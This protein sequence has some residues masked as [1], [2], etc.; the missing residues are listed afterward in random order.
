MLSSCFDSE[1]EK[2]VFFFTVYFF[3]DFV[4]EVIAGFLDRASAFRFNLNRKSKQVQPKQ[5]KDLV[6]YITF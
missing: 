6:D 5:E 1:L 4:E 3:C 2:T